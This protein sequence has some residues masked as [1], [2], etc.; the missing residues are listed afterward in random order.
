VTEPAPELVPDP[1]LL[2]DPIDDDL[3][4]KADWFLDLPSVPAVDGFAPDPAEP[5]PGDEAPDDPTPPPPAVPIDDTGPADV[6]VEPPPQAPVVVA[7]P[8]GTP[9]VAAGHRRARPV[10]ATVGEPTWARHNWVPT[11]PRNVGGRV[12]ALVGHPTEP[13]TLF[14]GAAAG[15]VYRTRD[16]GETWES[17]WHEQR[18][19]GVGALAVGRVGPDTIVFAA[20][21]EP[22]NEDRLYV[23]DGIHVS[24]DGG[25]TWDAA[26]APTAPGVAPHIGR[27]FEALAV[28][29]DDG[30]V[31]WAVG[32][33]GIFRTVDGGGTW[34]Q[35]RAGRRFT[36]AVYSPAV[37]AAGQRLLYLVP[38]ERHARG[39]IS[40]IRLEL[41]PHAPVADVDAALAAAANRMQVVPPAPPGGA[42]LPED[43]RP[44]RAK[45]AICDGTPGVAY[46]RV[47]RADG[48]H[49]LG[50]FRTLL[51]TRP[52]PEPAGTRWDRVRDHAHW[53]RAGQ[54]S[55]NLSVAV[56]P[57]EPGTLVTGMTELHLSFN[58]DRA[59][60]GAPPT[61]AADFIR[62]MAWDHHQRDRGHHADHHAALFHDDPG[63][64]RGALWVANDGGVS[65]SLDWHPAPPA[66]PDP[67]QLPAAKEWTA[68]ALPPGTG[69]AI[70]LTDEDN[71]PATAAVWRKRGHGIDATQMYSLSQHPLVPGTL[72]VGLQ[73]NGCWLTTG[74]RTWASIGGGDGGFVAFAPDDA[75]AMLVTSQNGVNRVLFP[76]LVDDVLSAE[77]RRPIPL[78]SRR[79]TGGFLRTD[80]PAYVADTAHHPRDKG[81]AYHARVGRLYGT[82]TAGEA[83][84]PLDVGD[85]L[86]ILH[87]RSTELRATLEVRASRAATVLGL[88]P[89]LHTD[90]VT[91]RHPAIDVEL[92]Q[93][94]VARV[95]CTQ[96][97][98]FALVAG[99]ELVLV[100]DGAP[101]RVPIAAHPIIPD[102]SRTTPAH[103]ASYLR[104]TQFPQLDARLRFE[105]PAGAVQLATWATGPATLD[106]DGDAFAVLTR[107][108]TP[109]PA[110]GAAPRLY[111]GEVDRPASVTLVPY[112]RDTT[113]PS[114]AGDRTIT[115]AVNGGAPVP[116][117]LDATSCADPSE[118]TATELA[119]AL[120]AR[121]D[122]AL[123]SVSTVS[124]TRRLQLTFLPAA[125]AGLR[126][127]GT[128][129]PRLGTEASRGR[130]R[131]LVPRNGE[132]FDLRP[133]GLAPLT[134]RIHDGALPEIMVRVHAPADVPDLSTVTLEEL[135][136]V[137][138]A[139][140]RA[141]YGAVAP[142]VRADITDLLPNE[143]S[144]KLKKSN[145][146]DLRF[147]PSD[148]DTLWVGS[149]SGSVF[150]SRDSGASWTAPA[151]DQLVRLTSS[152]RRVGAVAV[153][154]EDP[155]TVYL[156]HRDTGARDN[157]PGT[158]WRSTDGGATWQQRETGLRDG[159][160]RFVGVNALVV[161]PEAPEVVYAATEAGVFRSGDAGAS[162]HPFSEG[163]P[164]ARI[165]D[166][167]LEPRTR[168]LRVGAWGRG[169]YARHVGDRDPRDVQVFVR[170]HPLDLADRPAGRGS[171]GLAATPSGVP[172][173]NSPDI[174]LATVR[175]PVLG[176][177][178][179]DTAVD[180]VE[181]DL[182]VAHEP[183]EPGP[184]VVFVQVHNGG[185]AVPHDLRVVVLWTQVDDGP[186]PL[187][188]TLWPAYRAGTLAGDQGR[189]HVLVDRTLPDPAPSPHA[190]ASRPRVLT[191]VVDWPPGIAGM[192]T[193]GMVALVG[194]TED[195]LVADPLPTG[196]TDL[197]ALLQSD[198]HVAY[199]ETPVRAAR[200]GRLVVERTSPATFDLA[201]DGTAG[202]DGAV[203]RLRIPAVAG[204]DR[205]TLPGTAFNLDPPSAARR[206]RFT[207]ADR[208]LDI[209]FALRDPLLTSEPAEMATLSFA[210]V[211]AVISRELRRS[212]LPV[213]APRDTWSMGGVVVA[214][215]P[216]LQ[217]T[218]GSGATVAVTAAS[219][220]APQVV[221]L[222]IAGGFAVNRGAAAHVPHAPYDLTAVAAGPRLLRL[223]VR[224]SIAIRLDGFPDPAKV[225]V[226]QLRER[227]EREFRLRALPLR[228]FVGEIALRVRR[229]GAQGTRYADVVASP[230]AVAAGPA[231]Q[232]LF[233]IGGPRAAAVGRSAVT[234]LYLRTSNDGQAAQI[235]GRHRAFAI[236]LGAAPL[237]VTQLG[238]DVTATVP[239]GGAVVSEFPW[240]TSGVAAG[241]AIAVLCVA[242][243][244]GDVEVA[245]PATFPDLAALEVFCARPEAG[246]RFFRAE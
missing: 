196:E 135:R 181:F 167:A 165:V 155:Q 52:L 212:G 180:G 79:L 126:L 161:D 6:E 111:S 28:H 120:R 242:D 42:D 83:W 11:G 58:A 192:R 219:A 187:P 208:S 230:V 77:A 113:N 127:A 102:L 64:A 73:D 124:R 226:D 217:C 188:A 91:R 182:D 163:L 95:V 15:G 185:W 54:A 168:T 48:V 9:P 245:V 176:P 206:L 27:R 25:D 160:G 37:G 234:R 189:W 43:Q 216:L 8:R 223:R 22:D 172:L 231:R 30:E 75:Y 53:P 41:P 128:M 178:G 214:S 40:I 218:A 7:V 98:P 203:A 229:P 4:S 47:T 16:R 221:G 36:D 118:P 103:L 67:P 152:G 13:D 74:G 240:D 24:R 205:V 1:E 32:Q 164:N 96:P 26:G 213:G 106:L 204:L 62:I 137:I 170:A 199:R 174:K 92:Q 10:A 107:G 140:L 122:P 237:A 133:P 14:A 60:A 114:P 125:G 132:S 80:P 44:A 211:H 93:R 179:V 194:A 90:T 45:L 104:A 105:P 99:D 112:T 193:I 166:M 201:N 227:L 63:N 71:V 76:G 23:G 190:D 191:T 138:A 68:A 184:G 220:A 243:A 55:Y 198:R 108:A 225:T 246:F 244:P 129:L 207:I 146:V 228:A 158:L 141:H 5:E 51:A 70:A 50:L 235:D 21:G 89:Q 195:P 153:H 162:W 82:A 18:S 101:L 236:P 109:V 169:T 2:G 148:P 136:R 97:G 100:L 87:T 49:H 69:T 209:V 33:A 173:V 121:L 239:E 78:A 183:P 139:R 224:Q 156:G 29:P 233:D 72:A 59:A 56:H 149:T 110:L 65:R 171:D 17:L 200:R 39:A 61:V 84:H 86:E 186:P 241:A 94:A 3:S 134:L 202:P 232:R 81:R 143:P 177:P 115:V 12:R 144:S 175:P 238:V 117:R 142:K 131:H 57:H 150:V 20:T 46:L 85:R 210:Q 151:P 34:T 147:A 154:P 159:A 123:V 130:E 215:T 19:L 222:G 38:A 119:E 157:A 88:S 66:P 145:P 197:L 31:C 116:V 35:H